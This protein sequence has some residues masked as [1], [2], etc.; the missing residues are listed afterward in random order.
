[1]YHKPSFQ[2]VAASTYI[3]VT[4]VTSL[5]T[6]YRRGS[7]LSGGPRVCGTSNRNG[8]PSEKHIHICSHKYHPYRPRGKEAQRLTGCILTLVESV[9]AMRPL[10]AYFRFLE[11]SRRI[12]LELAHSTLIG[13][14]GIYENLPCVTV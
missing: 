4:L 11:T 8:G 2:I 13:E 5:V 7:Y 1:M 6:Y 10:P 14:Q 3:I 9:W 12:R